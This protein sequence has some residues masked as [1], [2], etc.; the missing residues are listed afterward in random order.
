MKT[1][2]EI[3][4]EVSIWWYGVKWNAKRKFDATVKWAEE[5]KELALAMIPV[6]FAAVKGIGSMVRSVD[7]KIDLKREQEL[8]DLYIYDR[9]L[10]MYHRLRRPL[11]PS[12]K[13]EIEARRAKGERLTTILADMRLLD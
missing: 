13:I 11:R 2:E 12:E 9:S 1:T 7:R 6:G 8:Q 4:T 10:G 5:N 3:K